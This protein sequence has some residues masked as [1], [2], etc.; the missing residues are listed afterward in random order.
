METPEGY[1]TCSATRPNS[2]QK[3]NFQYLKLIVF[4]IKLFINLNLRKD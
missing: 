1:L 2:A 3:V 4:L